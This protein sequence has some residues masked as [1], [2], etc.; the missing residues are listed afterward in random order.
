MCCPGGCSCG[1]NATQFHEDNEVCDVSP[2]SPSWRAWR[3]G[4]SSI[5][6]MD[7][8]NFL[9]GN[10]FHQKDSMTVGSTYMAVRHRTKD[11]ICNMMQVCLGLP[12]I[13]TC[14]LQTLQEYDTLSRELTSKRQASV[15]AKNTCGGKKNWWRGGRRDG[16]FQTARA[17]DLY[18]VVL[19][20]IIRTN[21]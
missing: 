17:L 11:R 6:F 13:V 9:V 5:S 18:C 1:E 12:N 3:T 2:T 21:K 10:Q 8:Y 19:E 14:Y 15:E 4:S 7:H 16:H 20:K